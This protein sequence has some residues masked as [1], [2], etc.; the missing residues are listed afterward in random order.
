[1][2]PDTPDNQHRAEDLRAQWS[3]NLGIDLQLHPMDA[4]AYQQALS[5]GNY[6]LAFGG[7]SADYPDPQDWLGTLFTCDSTFHSLHY[8]NSSFD[9]LMAR[10]DIARLSSERLQIYAQ[11]QTMLLQDLPVA[12]L[13]VRGHLVLVKP[14]VQTTDGRPLILTPMD[15]YP[16]S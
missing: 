2:F 15:E 9:Q 5:Q 7:W 16:G 13:F 4:D 1:S 6:D 12:P 14:W 8:C 3:V 11:A 10:A